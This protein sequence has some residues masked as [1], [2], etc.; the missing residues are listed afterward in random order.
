MDWAD[1]LGVPCMFYGFC[2]HRG[3]IRGSDK[4]VFAF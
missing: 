2:D 4:C 1:L 3:E